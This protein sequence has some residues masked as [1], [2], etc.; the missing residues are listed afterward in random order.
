M[1]R[2]DLRD[3]TAVRANGQGKAFVYVLPCHVEEI[4]KIG[5][6]R[7]PISRFEIFHSRYFEVFDLER[8]FLIETG[9][10]DE[11]RSVERRLIRDLNAH[12][13]PSPITIRPGAGGDTE[14]FRGAFSRAVELADAIVTETDYVCWTPL[15]NWLCQA[16]GSRADL[17]FE[18]SATAIATIT[19]ESIDVRSDSVAA[20]FSQR[21]TDKVDAYASMNFPV[22][23]LVTPEFLAWYGERT[24]LPSQD[25]RKE[26]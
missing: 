23:T 8:G 13:A 21:L 1:A 24:L 11:A 18:W 16:L 10:V 26:A 14:W 22:E 15:R 9:R 7:D 20:Q 4:L 5:F 25:R 3:P 6:S 12:N 2:I 19:G 17:L